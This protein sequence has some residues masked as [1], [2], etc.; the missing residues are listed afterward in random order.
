MQ[1]NS[2]QMM[3]GDAGAWLFENCIRR[4]RTGLSVVMAGPD[5]AISLRRAQCVPKRDARDE[6]GHGRP[7]DGVALLA[8]DPRIS[9]RDALCPPKRD[10]R[11]MGEP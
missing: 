3:R 11:N 1:P 2:A 10:G 4:E 9:L 6:R 7:K 5:P 8:Y